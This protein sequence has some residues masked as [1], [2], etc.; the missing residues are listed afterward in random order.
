MDQ[1]YVAVPQ[2]NISSQYSPSNVVNQDCGDYDM[3]QIQIPD[4]K[5]NQEDVL[6]KMLGLEMSESSNQRNDNMPKANTAE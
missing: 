4:N 6:R 3:D 5:P 2:Y 1:D